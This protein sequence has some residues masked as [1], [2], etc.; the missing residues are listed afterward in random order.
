MK[1]IRKIEPFIEHVIIG[2]LFVGIGLHIVDNF[3]DN[4]FGM[5]GFISI[6]WG[7]FK[8]LIGLIIYGVAIWAMIFRPESFFHIQRNRIVE[9]VLIKVRRDIEFGNLQ[10]AKGRLHGLILKYPNLLK[11]R[12]ELS[13]IYLMEKD[14]IN[15]GRYLYLKPKPTKQEQLYINHFENS[16]GNNPLQI[17]KK[18]SN[19][20]KINIEFVKDYK[21]KISELV[22]K[23]KNESEKTSWVINEYKYYLQELNTPFY[24][25]LMKNQKDLIIHSVILVILI[26]LT[27]YLKR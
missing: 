3:N 14:L 1:S 5:F 11:I 15:T 19:P 23:V 18:I 8:I 7:G 16:L 13:D 25:K 24:K 6:F 22:G 10:K 2:V 17:L 26:C 4:F 20:Y 21:S 27:E 12:I 9:K